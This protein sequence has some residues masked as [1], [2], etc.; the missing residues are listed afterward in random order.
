MSVYRIVV[1]T[2]VVPNA[3]TNADVWITLYGKDGTNS[4]ERFLDNAEDNFENGKTDTFTFDSRNL[5]DLKGVLIRHDNSGNKP[6]WFLDRIQVFNDSELNGAW[7][8]PCN[9]WLAVD[10]DDGQISRFL[11]VAD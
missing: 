7:T 11:A 2:G 8:F 4:G 3:G 10:E 1:V 6:G 5:G 9:R